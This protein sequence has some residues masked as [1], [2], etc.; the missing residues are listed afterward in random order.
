MVEGR[1]LT[2][3]DETNALTRMT[4][5]PATRAVTP[6]DIPALSRLHAC[7]FGPGRFA[8]SAYRVREGQGPLSRFC[9]LAIHE[10]NIVAALR[11]T[12]AA[13]GMRT[14]AALLGPLAVHPDFRG[15]GFGKQLIADAIDAMRDAGVELVV[16]VGDLPYYGRFGF[17]AVPPGQI[18]FPGPVNPARI[19]ALELEDGALTRYRG[20]V[21]ASPVLNADAGNG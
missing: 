18:V 9:R 21:S 8:R 1:S 6:A 14:G 7:V 19:L 20:K 12:E 11:M 5:K 15:Q 10:G 3:P 13:I 2:D 16:L 4:E 17:K